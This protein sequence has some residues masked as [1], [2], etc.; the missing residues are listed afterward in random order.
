MRYRCYA[1]CLFGLEAI[2][3]A[4]LKQMGIEEI[5]TKDARVYFFGRRSADRAGQPLPSERR[6]SLYCFETVCC[7]NF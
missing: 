4:E 5:E 1:A 6:Q 2:V 3:A 7:K